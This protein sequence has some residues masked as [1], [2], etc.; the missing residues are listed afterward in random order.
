MTRQRMFRLQVF[1][2]GQWGTINTRGPCAVEEEI[3]KIRAELEALKS[4]WASNYGR[5]QD[6]NFRILESES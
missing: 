4:R 2:N 1:T 5:F 6:A 3:Q